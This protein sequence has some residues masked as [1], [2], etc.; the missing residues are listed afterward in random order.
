M[1]NTIEAYLD[2]RSTTELNEVLLS[3]SQVDAPG[4]QLESQIDA[5]VQLLAEAQASC[6]PADDED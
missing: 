5:I 6:D 4:D 1:N 3:R 2:A